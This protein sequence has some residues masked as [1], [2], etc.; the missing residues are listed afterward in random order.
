MLLSS[1]ARSKGPLQLS[2]LPWHIYGVD[3][4]PH[5]FKT[6]TKDVHIHPVAERPWHLIELKDKGPGL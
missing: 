5:V 3:G 2:L 1:T 4:I 6:A